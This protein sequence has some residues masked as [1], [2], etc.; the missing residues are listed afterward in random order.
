MENDP[1]TYL[2]P[3]ILDPSFGWLTFNFMGH[4]SKPSFYKGHKWV[5]GIYIYTVYVLN[6]F[7]DDDNFYSSLCKRLPVRV[8]H[9]LC[10]QLLRF[11]GP[12]C[13]WLT[14]VNSEQTGAFVPSFQ[15]NIVFLYIY[16][17]ICIL[18][19]DKSLVNEEFALKETCPFND[20]KNLVNMVIFQHHPIGFHLINQGKN[21]D[22]GHCGIHLLWTLWDPLRNHWCSPL[23]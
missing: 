13:T 19:I 14:T 9:S 18:Y 2:E 4:M 20:D 1:F 10:I 16:I 6:P 11:F 5:P 17:Y 3:S 15:L 12:W 7:K 23:L 22:A 21:N 8:H